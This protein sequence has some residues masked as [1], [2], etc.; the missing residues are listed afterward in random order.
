MDGIRKL[1]LVNVQREYIKIGCTEKR[2]GWV[3]YA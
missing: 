1:A 2:D 3:P